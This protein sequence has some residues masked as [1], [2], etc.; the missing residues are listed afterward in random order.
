MR[1]VMVTLCGALYLFFTLMSWSW[2]YQSGRL[3]GISKTGTAVG[4]SRAD[5]PTRVMASKQAWIGILWWALANSF[6][7]IGWRWLP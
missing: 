4:P 6:A 5:L 2:F 7:A 1:V 3:I